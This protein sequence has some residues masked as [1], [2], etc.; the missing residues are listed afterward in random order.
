M[1]Y[2][3][4]ITEESKPVLVEAPQKPRNNI[5]NPLAYADSWMKYSDEYSK[6]ISDKSKHIQFRDDVFVMELV[7]KLSNNEND[8][9]GVGQTFPIPT[10]YKVSFEYQIRSIFGEDNWGNINEETYN[11]ALNNGLSQA[12]VRKLAILSKLEEEEIDVND[13]T[14]KPVYTS[15]QKLKVVAPS[16]EVKQNWISVKDRLP[17]KED[18]YLTY[19]DDGCYVMSYYN[20]EIDGSNWLM[21]GFTHFPTHWMPLP[22]KPL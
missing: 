11:D 4:L 1:N 2:L 20:N 7:R 5:D 17:E 22:K 9:F 16:E 13:I 18:R 14:I 21:D 3:I 10:G 19:Q 8:F 6:A 15:E 12:H